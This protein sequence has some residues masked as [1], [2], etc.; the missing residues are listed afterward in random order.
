MNSV[1]Y[2]VRR[3]ASLCSA[4][5]RL[6][7]C[8]AVALTLLVA[9]CAMP[10]M[11][12][13]SAAPP[14]VG[15]GAAAWQRQRRSENGNEFNL[16]QTRDDASNAATSDG[17]ESMTLTP[18]PTAETNASTVERVENGT[19]SD[20]MGNVSSVCVNTSSNIASS[21]LSPSVNNASSPANSQTPGSLLLVGGN[22]NAPRATA[23][24]SAVVS[25]GTSTSADPPAPTAVETVWREEDESVATLFRKLM[26]KVRREVT[27]FSENNVLLVLGSITAVVCL[28]LLIPS[29][30]CHLRRCCRRQRPQLE[31][32]TSFTTQVST[33]V[34]QYMSCG[35]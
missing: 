11:H 23:T 13:R 10:E 18:T 26:K 25:S 14:A 30:V 35:N 9:S 16:S 8:S 27:E 33:Q 31:R 20:A 1:V 28:I 5:L 32:C 15:R 34:T 21:L 4:M 22:A 17:D 2:S 12:A 6:L 19:T 24:G 7:L 29:L 3:A